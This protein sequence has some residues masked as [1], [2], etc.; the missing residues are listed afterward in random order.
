MEKIVLRIRKQLA[1]AR[2]RSAGRTQYSHQLKGEVVA[3][4]TA[5]QDVGHSRQSVSRELG[6]NPVTLADWVRKAATVGEET[7]ASMLPVAVVSAD[8]VPH[9]SQHPVVHGPL[10]VRVEGLDVEGV[11]DLLRRLA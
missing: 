4:A 5:L 8:E 10:G 9:D 6:L 2:R 3:V 7:E 1:A 11:A